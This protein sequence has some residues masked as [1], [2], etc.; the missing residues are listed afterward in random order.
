MDEQKKIYID[1]GNEPARMGLE[2]KQKK[3]NTN[4]YN[5]IKLD[6]Y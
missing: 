1:E 6:H 3:R 5:E 2:T 4:T